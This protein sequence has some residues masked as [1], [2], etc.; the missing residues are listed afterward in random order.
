MQ[1]ITSNQQGMS[2]TEKYIQDIDCMRSYAA[3]RDKLFYNQTLQTSV[4]LIQSTRKTPAKSVKA[5]MP[6]VDYNY[7]DSVIIA[8][9]NDAKFINI[10]MNCRKQKSTLAYIFVENEYNYITCII[11]TPDAFPIMIIRL[12]IDKKFIYAKNGN[13]CYEFPLVDIISKD[14]KFNKS[15][16]YSMTLKA[17]GNSVQ[18]IYDIYNASSEPNRITIENI[19]VGS[20]NIIDNLFRTMMA[21]I[22]FMS[23]SSKQQASLNNMHETPSLLTFDTMNILI[24]KEAT[25]VNTINFNTKQSSNS[26]NYF[27]IT[28]DQRLLYVAE[29]NKKQNETYICSREDSITWNVAD[30]ED[31]Y[32]M[33]PFDSLFK[34]NYNRSVM[35]NDRIYY[36]FATFLSNYMFVKVITSLEV[37]SN[38]NTIIDTFIK[39][40]N[41]KYQIL[42]AYM[43]TRVAKQNQK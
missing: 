17:N 35:Q 21:S 41:D 18:F 34:I 30:V 33:Q 23:F 28:D 20:M 27:K 9:Q 39:T 40:F 29:T 8:I 14:I 26:N 42:E 4:P 3:V 37:N 25:S 24:L 19:N 22:K 7:D 36:I 31:E 11:K 16:S 15:S 2:I 1:N 38:T 43:C 32:T 5:V 10:I 12:P 13:N 6:V